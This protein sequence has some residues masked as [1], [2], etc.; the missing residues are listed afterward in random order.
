MGLL[1]RMFLVFA[2][3]MALAAAVLLRPARALWL[4]TA[5][6]SA[7]AMVAL[8]R[9]IGRTNREVARFIEAVHFGDLTVT[10]TAR[11][12]GG[13][14]DLA[15][16]INIALQR[17][18]A[19]RERLT[20]N[21]RFFE[22]VIDNVPIAML[23]V[24]GGTKVTLLNRTA[25][26]LFG[27]VPG[28]RPAD[29]ASLSG[30]FVASLTAARPAER[31][32]IELALPGGHQRAVVHVTA[33]GRLAGTMRLVAVQ[34]IQDAL[35]D[36]EL[37]AQ[38]DLVRLLTHEIMNSLTPISSLAQSVVGLV[39]ESGGDTQPLLADAREAADALARRADGL[40]SF[41]QS[42][43]QVSRPPAIRR[44]RFPARPFA[45]EIAALF[46]SEWP[47]SMAD[48]RLTVTPE[49]LAIHAD[50]D[51]LAQVL[52]NLLRNAAEASEDAKLPVSIALT[53][54]RAV[55]SGVRILV[56]D[57]GPGIPDLL[58]K[59]VF[60]PFFTTKPSGTGVGLSF[61]KQVVHAHDG[62]I[63]VLSQVEG[64]TSITIHI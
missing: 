35:T 32:I 64:G 34:P 8:W 28:V 36:A 29:F 39:A 59:E 15:R 26:R 63:E 38:S 27:S 9:Y 33:I 40:M 2:T 18:R 42:F 43:R 31:Q 11:R 60:L 53:I 5:M 7:G 14:D 21:N 24:E 58:R 48:L 16:A 57:Q 3:L 17:L 44:R 54:E 19:E 25:R 50:P 41:V 49:D 12:G 23:T 45:Q 52:L 62:A 6:L 46:R 56:T 51:L 61:A 10:F 22:A 30:A 55:P 4:T 47:G 1:W 20:Y 13:F 37:A